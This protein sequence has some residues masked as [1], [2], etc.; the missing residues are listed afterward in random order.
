MPAWKKSPSS[1]DPSW[2][3][4]WFKFDVSLWCRFRTPC[5]KP[6]VDDPMMGVGKYMDSTMLGINSCSFTYD[7]TLLFMLDEGVF[8]SRE[9]GK[10]FK[11]TSYEDIYLPVCK[12]AYL[13]FPM[14]MLNLLM[15]RKEKW[16]WIFESVCWNLWIPTCFRS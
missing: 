15:R 7:F 10:K 5:H 8:R 16:S 3:K 6:A 12:L 1:C 11:I 2:K 13:F 14:Q 4:N 9:E